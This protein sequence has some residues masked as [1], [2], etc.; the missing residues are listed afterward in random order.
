MTDPNDGSALREEDLAALA[1]YVKETKI[2]LSKCS[3]VAPITRYT[4]STSRHCVEFLSSRD[5]C[6][7][8]MC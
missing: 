3:G 1:E 2:D 6:Y 8:I 7:R 4:G 5:G